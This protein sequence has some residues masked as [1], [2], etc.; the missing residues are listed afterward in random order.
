MEL[1]CRLD[2]R[3]LH[4][5]AYVFDPDQPDLAPNSPGSATTACCAPGH[6]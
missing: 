2:G 1:S 3:S 6:G 5:L 4:L